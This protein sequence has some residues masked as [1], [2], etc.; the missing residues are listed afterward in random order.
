M[1]KVI[2]IEKLYSTLKVISVNIKYTQN[3]S[4]VDAPWIQKNVM[5]YPLMNVLFYLV[6]LILKHIIV[7][8]ITLYN[9]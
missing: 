5:M 9:L 8:N 4:F 1:V 3:I 2:V 6:Y 7:Q